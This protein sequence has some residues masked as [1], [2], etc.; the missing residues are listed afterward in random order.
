MTAQSV[1]YPSSPWGPLANDPYSPLIDPVVGSAWEAAV[2]AARQ[3]RLATA[4][5]SDSLARM[6]NERE[7]NNGETLERVSPQARLVKAVPR[8]PSIRHFG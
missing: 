6:H 1:K 3:M 4:R 8:Q 5:M 2:E 7:G